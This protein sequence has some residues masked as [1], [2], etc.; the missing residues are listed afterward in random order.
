MMTKPDGNKIKAALDAGEDITVDITP[1]ET[2]AL[3]EIDGG[4]SSAFMPLYVAQAGVYPLRIV[5]FEGEGGANLE[6]FS[7]DST[8]ERSLDQ[9]PV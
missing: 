5:W 8:G 6:W 1:D 3:G 4:A 7:F 9:R 2:P